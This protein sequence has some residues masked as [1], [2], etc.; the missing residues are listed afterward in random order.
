[1][2]RVEIAPQDNK[3]RGGSAV[4]R[5]GDTLD[6]GEIQG[7]CDTYDIDWLEVGAENERGPGLIF[8]WNN[9]RNPTN[10]ECLHVTLEAFD[11]ISPDDLRRGIISGRDVHHVSR[12]VGYYS[13]IENWNQSKIGELRDRRRGDYGVGGRK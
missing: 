4:V 3:R 8:H 10:G 1:M 7:F 5:K 9:P 2:A 13:R 12:V 6:R 11:S